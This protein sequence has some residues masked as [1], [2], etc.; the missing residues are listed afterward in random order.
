M[1]GIQWTATANDALTTI[2]LNRR[3][4]VGFIAARALRQKITDRVHLLREF[5]QLGRQRTTNEE[6]RELVV[7]PYIIPYQIVGDTV[8][9]LD[10]FHAR[11]SSPN[12]EDDSEV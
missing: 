12:E 6:G 11:F 3:Q 10:I 5:P 9:I 4:Q 7:P 8:F 2:I 1:A